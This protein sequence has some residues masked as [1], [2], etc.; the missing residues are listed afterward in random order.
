M[1]KTENISSFALDAGKASVAVAVASL[2]AAG[3][4]ATTLSAS[5]TGKLSY[6]KALAGASA[7]TGG[8]TS[9]STLTNFNAFLGSVY[10]SGE[11]LVLTLA[12]NASFNTTATPSLVCFDGAASAGPTTTWQLFDRGTNTL[13]FRAPLNTATTYSSTC[14]V[15]GVSL[16]DSTLDTVGETVSITA[17][18]QSQGGS[19]FD[20]S[21]A[22]KTVAT[23]INSIAV[24]ASTANRF[25][26]VIDPTSGNKYFKTTGGATDSD[27]LTLTFT[28]TA[29]DVGLTFGTGTVGSSAA[30]LTIDVSGD[31]NFLVNNGTETSANLLT[32][33][34]NTAAASTLTNSVVGSLSAVYTGSSVTGLRLRF[35]DS[36]LSS[37]ASSSGIPLATITVGQSGTGGNVIPAQTFTGSYTINGLGGNSGSESVTAVRSAVSF[38]PGAFTQG[39]ATVFVPY[40]PVGSGINQVVYLANNSATA[41]T[42]TVVAKGQAGGSCSTSAVTV[43]ANGNTNLSDALAAAI[44]TCQ[45]AGTIA[46]T[47]KLMLTITASTPVG[48]TEVYSSFTVSG[49]SRVTVPNSSNGYKSGT[50]SIGADNAN[51]N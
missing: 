30:A 14:T 8:A 10:N 9:S 16:L 35:T 24:G 22:A 43:A 13:K 28:S 38:T 40:M 41:G 33:G 27:V 11:V 34:T 6:E 3:A 51:N 39:G 45:S 20:T 4:Q 12:S 46:A 36:G 48:N 49:S 47:D 50:G 42:A 2:C 29:V 1:S 21:G 15:S 31:F 37:L 17:S 32:A 5:A 25:N 26:A 7:A 19:A 44:S 18:G 23:V